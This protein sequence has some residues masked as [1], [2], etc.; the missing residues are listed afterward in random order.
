MNFPMPYPTQQNPT[1]AKSPGA[2]LPEGGFLATLQT[3]RKGATLADLEVNLQKVVEAVREQ[4]KPGTMTWK[5]VV[6]PNSKGSVEILA[7]D[8][9][10][11]LKLP[12]AEGGTTIYYAD[13]QN[14][15]MRSDPKQM[16]MPA[17]A[18]VPKEPEAPIR[19]ITAQ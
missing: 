4:H 18:E 1:G 17:L 5:V 14:R 7:I 9:E 6:S 3:M 2:Q 11:T 10:V 13:D 16:E 15:L 8:D 19:Q 12:K